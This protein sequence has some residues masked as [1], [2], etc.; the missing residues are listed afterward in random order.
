M[1]CEDSVLF[2]QGR[3]NG[4]DQNCQRLTKN[5][6]QKQRRLDEYCN[7]SYFGTVVKDACPLSC[8]NCPID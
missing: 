8:D 3:R 7:K 4:N 5:R 2:F 6:I 1:S